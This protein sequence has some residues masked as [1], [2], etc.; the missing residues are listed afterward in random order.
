MTEDTTVQSGTTY[1]E[2]QEEYVKGVIYV[3][4]LG[5]WAPQSSGDIYVPIAPAEIDALF[6]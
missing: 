2:R 3:Y 6:A 5:G 4:E 1:Y